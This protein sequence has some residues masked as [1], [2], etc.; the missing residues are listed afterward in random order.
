MYSFG[1]IVHFGRNTNTNEFKTKP[2]CSKA[3]QLFP[4]VVQLTKNI[5]MGTK[6]F[7]QLWKKLYIL[8]QI[9]LKKNLRPKHSVP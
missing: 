6:E 7:L 3:V 1:K 5:D 8:V 9:Q 4:L 2:Q